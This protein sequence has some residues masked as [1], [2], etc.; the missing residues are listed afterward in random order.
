MSMLFKVAKMG[1]L[2]ITCMKTFCGVGRFISSEEN[3]VLLQQ[4]QVQVSLR[5]LTAVLTPF[6]GRL[7]LSPD[8][9]RHT[10]SV[11]MYIILRQNTHVHTIIKLFW[12]VQVIMMP[13]FFRFFLGGFSEK[14]TVATLRELQFL[15][16]NT[17]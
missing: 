13:V 17:E 16:T 15:L 6:P 14:R 7:I 11:Q 8:F 9:C 2:L 5:Q 4:I 10:H 12:Q 3:Q 1:T